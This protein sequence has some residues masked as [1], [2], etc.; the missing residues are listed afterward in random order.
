MD[1]SW[2]ITTSVYLM[3]IGLLLIFVMA[4]YDDQAAILLFGTESRPGTTDYHYSNLASSLVGIPG[5]ILAIVGL[6]LACRKRGQNQ[7]NKSLNIVL[8][9]ITVLYLIGALFALFIALSWQ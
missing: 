7:L 9:S 5:L 1:K 8:G 2:K 6:I 4:K 3:F